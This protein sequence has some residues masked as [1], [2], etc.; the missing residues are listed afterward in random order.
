M[1]YPKIKFK[2]SKVQDKKIFKEFL[3][4]YQ[5]KQEKFFRWLINPHPEFKT[6]LDKKC[7]N[8]SQILKLANNFTHEFY[9]KNQKK[10]QN[11]AKRIEKKWQEK[12]KCF[13][14]LV[15]HLFYCHPW[16]EGKYIGY[17]TIWGI[18]PRY[19]DQKIFMV[20]YKH[21]IKNYALAT[22]AHELLHFMF[23]DYVLK[24]FP[25]FKNKKY[26]RKIWEVSEIF[27]A[28]VQQSY[29]WIKLFG[30]KPLIYTEHQKKIKKINKVWQPK[31]G[32][33]EFLK[34]IL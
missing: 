13:F 26:D 6:M 24:H 22:I 10:I 30:V 31:T 27:N 4:Y 29:P 5:T 34:I 11:N 14:Q 7:L 12:E 23:Y 20:P 32:I 25:K 16:P 19:L 8:R 18:F 17:M 28:V 2:T 15:D 21:K 3:Q 33:K 9:K 1:R